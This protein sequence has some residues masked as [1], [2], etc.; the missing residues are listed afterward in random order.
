MPGARLMASQTAPRPGPL[1]NGEVFPIMADVSTAPTLDT[2]QVTRLP[3][4]AAADQQQ[5]QARE[6]TPVERQLVA[7][8][9]A[10]TA[11]LG[12]LGFINSFARVQ[13][14]A[15]ASFG[16][17]A[18][19]VPLGV[20]L[21]I[22]VFSALDIVLSRL[23]MRIR[24]LRLIPWTLTA[25]TVYLNVAP[26]LE[27]THVDGFSVVSHAVLP[28]LWVI[29]VEVGAY[30]LRRRAGIA[31]GTR[32]DT[33]RVSRWLLAPHTTLALWR[34]MVLWEEPSYTHALQRERAR[35]LALADLKATYGRNW[36]RRATP[37]EKALYRLGEHPT[38]T[39]GPAAT[40]SETSPATTPKRRPASGKADTAAAAARLR[41]RHPDMA[42][43]EI[44]RRLGVS[45][46][47]VRRHLATT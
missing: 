45:D 40:A 42:V 34:R 41:Q 9:V 30:I 23:D 15:Q 18:F 36:K 27:K 28:G 26:E 3:T 21:G 19:T 43:V 33:I 6:L 13:A 4:A 5:T 39:A 37:R 25:A 20:D 12:G 38:P 7:G 44:A 29:A 32:M 31:A 22:A 35:V 24:W 11:V 8:V 2:R 47:T 10:A 17:W 16:F 14:A 46:R 1:T